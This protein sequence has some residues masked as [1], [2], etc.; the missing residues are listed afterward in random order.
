MLHHIYYSV[1]KK[2]ESKNRPLPTGEDGSSYSVIDYGNTFHFYE[3]TQ[4]QLPDFH[5]G[6]GW[7]SIRK[8][9]F[10][11]FIDLP[12]IIHILKKDRR[13]YNISVGSTRF[14]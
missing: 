2:E 12:K 8:I 3:T 4:R 6:A 14:L 10:I 5:A 1:N 11:D 13:F 9:G 7:K